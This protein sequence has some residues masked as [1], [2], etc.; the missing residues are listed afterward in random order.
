M[1]AAEIVE[2]DLTYVNGRFERGVRNYP[3]TPPVWPCPLR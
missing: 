3:M 2:A 1:T